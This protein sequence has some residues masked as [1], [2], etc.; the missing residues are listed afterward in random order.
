MTVGNLLSFME[1]VLNELYIAF[2]KGEKQTLIQDLCNTLEQTEDELYKVLNE[3]HKEDLSSAVTNDSYRILP[4]GVI[5]VET[6][7]LASELLIYEN[8]EL[9]IKMLNEFAVIHERY[10]GSQSLHVQHM[11]DS[12]KADVYIVLNNAD[13]LEYLQFVTPSLIGD[14]KI[15]KNG[16][17]EL[18]RSKEK[19]E[20]SLEFK[21]ILSMEPH[22]RGRE[23]Q[24]F[25]AKLA[26]RE[27]WKVE[28]SAKTSNEE[29]D[30]VLYRDH[31]FFLVECKWEGKPI[32]TLVIRDFF[33]KLDLRE[34]VKGII[35]SMS[36]FTSGSLEDV[37]D[38]MGKRIILLFGPNDVNSLVDGNK[39]LED[40]INEK[41]T[42]LIIKKKVLF[43]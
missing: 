43:S 21:Q 20:L 22:S 29:F 17:L 8:R 39:K 28:V 9:R 14:F 37:K 19:E 13:V 18:Q 15:T 2:S 34:G 10:R 30:V 36:G 1:K 5:F 35:V 31:E 33:A 3:L 6:N 27:G 40:L 24:N 38:R 42:Q 11:A 26:S 16:L 25:F 12:L 4:K 32:E 41:H 23:F 7:K